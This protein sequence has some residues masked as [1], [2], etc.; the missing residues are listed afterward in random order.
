[1]N[2][3]DY[4]CPDCDQSLKKSLKNTSP[5]VHQ[6]AEPPKELTCSC[7]CKA[8]RVKDDEPLGALSG[9]ADEYYYE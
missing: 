8:K 1:M 4:R 3:V 6:D 5:V 7:G 9:D 2:M